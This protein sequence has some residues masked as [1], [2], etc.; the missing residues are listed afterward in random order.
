MAYF[1]PSMSP[2]EK[3]EA[4]LKV[5]KFLHKKHMET[6]GLLQ[7]AAGLGIICHVPGL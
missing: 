2:R 3:A 6:N 7:E 5:E 4:A 1:P